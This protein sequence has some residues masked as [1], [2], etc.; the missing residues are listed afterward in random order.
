MFK[1]K[2]PDTL[3]FDVIKKQEFPSQNRGIRAEYRQLQTKLDQIVNQKKGT[4]SPREIRM[5]YDENN[6]DF[7]LVWVNWMWS[8]TIMVMDDLIRLLSQFSFYTPTEYDMN[9]FVTRGVL[10]RICFN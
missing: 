3:G 9:G 6:P 5:K 2:N 8:P 1:P 7:S 4:K 10:T